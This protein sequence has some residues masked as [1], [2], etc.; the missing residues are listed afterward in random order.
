L[1][2]FEDNIADAERLIALT[3]VLLNT[4]TYR[5]RRELRDSFGEA[6]RVPR[7]KWDE[8]DCVESADVF[9]LLKPGGR[10]AREHFT[11]PQLRPL[12]RQSVVAISAAVESYVAEKACSLLSRAMKMDPL[13]ARL[14]E[15]SV[16]LEDVLWIEQNYERRGWGHRALIRQYLVA[17]SSSD[18]DQIGRVFS[19]VGKSGLWP[20]VDKHRNTSKGVSEK[21]ARALAER[22]NQIAHSGDRVGRG[23]ALLTLEEV[24]GFYTNAKATVEA[25]D[26]VL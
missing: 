5:M 20:S 15:V 24:E 18:P 7:K 23:R 21:Q 22:R 9:L 10:A 3:R 16:S 17:E 14:R 8:L 1:D 25:I 4:R 26:A 19:T 2:V 13:P 11:E 12:L 6:M